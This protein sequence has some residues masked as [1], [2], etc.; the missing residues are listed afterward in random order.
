M[1]FSPVI[2]GWAAVPA[3]L[4]L[5]YDTVVVFLM[6]IRTWNI[7]RTKIAG[8]SGIVATLIKD[9]LMY[10]GV[11]LTTNLTL[12]IM[13]IK[14]VPGLKTIAAQF[15]F[16]ITV[17]M[18]SRITLNLRKNMYGNPDPTSFST[19]PISFSGHNVQFK[20]T[21]YRH[22]GA[23]A[24]TTTIIGGSTMR[25]PNHDPEADIV[26]AETHRPEPSLERAGDTRVT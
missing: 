14:S 12:I 17:T 25:R 11:I 10:Y 16:L 3:F 18:I 9:G 22:E 5:L 21:T 2:G 1:V 13:I 15:E 24:E 7:A 19:I 20:V 8:H 4:P 6:L 23:T 26:I